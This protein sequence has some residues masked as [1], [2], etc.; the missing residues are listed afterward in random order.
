MMARAMRR[1][2]EIAM[3]SAL[4]ATRGQLVR[5]L[6]CEGLLFA[7]GG[8]T[9]GVLVARASVNVL[10]HAAPLAVPDLHGGPSDWLLSAVVIAFR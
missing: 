10:L 8:G 3:R 4:G 7:L 1:A 6:A 5:L 9:L 2:R